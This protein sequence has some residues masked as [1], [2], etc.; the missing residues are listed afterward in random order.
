MSTLRWGL[1]PRGAKDVAIGNSPTN[2]RSETVASK[3][4]FRSAFRRRRC[5]IFADGFYEWQRSVSPNQPYYIHR[6]DDRPFAMAG[7]RESWDS[8][9]SVLETCAI[10]TTEA[11]ELM[12]PIHDRMPVIVEAKDYAAWLDP[13]QE[14]G[15]SLLGLRRP[16]ADDDFETYIISTRANSA[17][18]QGPILLKEAT[19]HGHANGR[20]SNE[21]AAGHLYCVLPRCGVPGAKVR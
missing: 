8:G 13:A 17:R 18:N 19:R 5:L 14:G 21:V 1:A 4:A 3:P 12:R 10:V 16:Y 6:P 2:A 7:V 20:C 9:D 15:D 11:N